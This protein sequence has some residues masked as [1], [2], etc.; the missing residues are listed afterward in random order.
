M[1]YGKAMELIKDIKYVMYREK[2]HGKQIGKV[3]WIQKL[4]RSELTD[5]NS[6]MKI[7]LE[8][9]YVFRSGDFNYPWNP[10]PHDMMSDDWIVKEV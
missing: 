2:W 10:S 4:G 8:G 3:M 7:I 1:E 9:I 5:I 6:G